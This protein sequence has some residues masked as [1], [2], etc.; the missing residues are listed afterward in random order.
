ME[1]FI[2]FVGFFILVLISF[3]CV[4]CSIAYAGARLKLLKAKRRLRECTRLMDEATLL[5]DDLNSA[6]GDLMIEV[7]RLEQQAAQVE[8]RIIN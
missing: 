8:R 2:N 3:W 6:N 7:E 5:I 4:F 1:H